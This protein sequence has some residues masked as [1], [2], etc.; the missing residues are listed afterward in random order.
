MPVSSSQYDTTC[1]AA[2]VR[3]R[4][5][6][7]YHRLDDI[8]SQIPQNF[9]P[10]KHGCHRSC[11]R[12]FTNVF[13][14]KDDSVE[15]PDTSLAATAVQTSARTAKVRAEYALLPRLNVYFAV[16]N[17]STF[18]EKSTSEYLSKCVTKTAAK[19]IFDCAT[20]T[21]DF[22]LLDVDEAEP[23]VSVET[24]PV[25][26]KFEDT[27]GRYKPHFVKYER[28]TTIHLSGDIS[29]EIF[30]ATE[31]KK[32]PS[33]NTTQINNRRFWYCECCDINYQSL[34]EH[35]KSSTQDVCADRI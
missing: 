32:S 19:K 15:D 12:R 16:K 7:D 1:K 27:V 9:D 23:A 10:D 6:A 24:L 5:T 31:M 17:A 29:R 20:S 2:A 8:C 21:D 26:V 35:M 13:R 25:F 34:T 4:Q 11:Y 18:E 33:H 30:T 28:F 14:L 3:Q 22:S